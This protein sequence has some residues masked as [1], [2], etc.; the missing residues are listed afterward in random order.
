MRGRELFDNTN[1]EAE[2]SDTNNDQY[3][4]EDRQLFEGEEEHKPAGLKG[5]VIDQHCLLQTYQ[6]MDWDTSECRLRLH[7]QP[8]G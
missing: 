5:L 4:S 3:G 1:F 2:F 7:S 6:L 8:Q